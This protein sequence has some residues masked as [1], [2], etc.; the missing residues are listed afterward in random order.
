VPAD[1]GHG[2]A[3]LAACASPLGLEQA[4]L[5]AATFDPARC[6]PMPAAP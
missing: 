5:T 6:T 1:D 4:A 3:D 2:L